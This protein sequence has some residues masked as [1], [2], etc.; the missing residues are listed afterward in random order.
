MTS[1]HDTLTLARGPAWRNR[2]ML[3]PL[4]NSQSHDD[5]TLSDEEFRWL[6]KRAEGGFGLVMTCASHVQAAGRGFPGQLGCFSDQHLPGLARLA[7]EIR[8]HGA[9]SS[10]QL[11]HAGIRSPEKLIGQQ[12]V[13][14]SDHADTKSRALTLDEVKH[15]RDD[16]IAAAV[17]AEK[18]GFDGVELHGA[19]SYILCAF[20]S[21]ETNQRTDAYGGSPENRARIVHEIIDG[22][23]SHTRAD[24][25]L[26]VR[27]SPER[28]G[29]VTTE[30]MALAEGLMTGGRI[31]YLD[32]SLWDVFKEPE[33]PALKGRPLMSLFTELKRG[34][35]RLGAAGK[36]VTGE[37]AADR[38]KHG[39]DF[40]VI[41]RSAILH[42]DWPRRIAADPQARPAALPVTAQHLRDEGLSDTFVTYMRNWKG[43]VAEEAAA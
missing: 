41:G 34:N 12:P 23:R 27:L 28:F 18:A 14:P 36:I 9:V 26:G 22:I 4:T 5:G 32:M 17:R 8:K 24:F 29:L 19:H 11:H 25:Q 20:L 37:H 16:F 6:T 13:G 31:D 35:T 10:V 2:F 38:L 3:A 39:L 1:L 43:F 15:L 30:M 21:P 40:V 33:D 42:H 7:A